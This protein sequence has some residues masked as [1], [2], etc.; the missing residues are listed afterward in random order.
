MDQINWHLPDLCISDWADYRDVII[1]VG[2]GVVGF[3]I[4]RI[5]AVHGQKIIRL[6]EKLDVLE[7]RPDILLDPLT[8]SNLSNWKPNGEWSIEEDGILSVTNTRWGGFYKI[9][10]TW[11]NYIFEFE[12][13]IINKCAGWIVRYDAGLLGGML[14]IQCQN[15][16]LRPHSR[17]S[18]RD[19]KV[20][21]EIPLSEEL[22]EWNKGS[23]EVKG[24]TVKVFINN[25]L[26]WQK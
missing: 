22:K 20:I 25:A 19:F 14:M 4:Y 15:D 23:T 6:E 5:L 18:M 16:K 12:F 26:I 1:K 10:S 2:L 21:N 11:E 9:G 3:G 8:A 24:D 17:F 13:K 7:N